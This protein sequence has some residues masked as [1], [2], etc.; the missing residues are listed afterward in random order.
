MRKSWNFT[1]A[2]PISAAVSM[3]RKQRSR[4]RLWLLDTSATKAALIAGTPA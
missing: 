1:A 3:K 2:Q 4:S